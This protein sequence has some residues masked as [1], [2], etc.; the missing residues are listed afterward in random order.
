M[1]TKPQL[2]RSWGICI[3][4]CYTVGWWYM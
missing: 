4:S 1:K 3:I 2:R